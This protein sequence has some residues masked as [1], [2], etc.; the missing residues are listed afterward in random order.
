M[1]IIRIALLLLIFASLSWAQ[2]PTKFTWTA[3]TETD[4]AGY[5]VYKCSLSPCIKTN[6]V[7]IGE[8][9]VSASPS[10]P[11]P[12]GAEGFV[13][14]TA[15]DKTGN[16]SGPSNTISFD[17]AAPLPPGALRLE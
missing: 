1:K 16:E 12:S 11:I 2:A 6:G 8:V 13:F 14:V 9:G 3:N 5:R 7:K 4:L 10:F 17:L 15:F